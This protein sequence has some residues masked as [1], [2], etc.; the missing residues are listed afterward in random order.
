MKTDGMIQKDVIDELKWA[1]PLSGVSSQIGVSVKDGVV[2]LSGIVDSYSKKIAA[3]K[4]AQKIQGVKV[5]ASDIV[6]KIGPYGVKTDSEIAEAIMNA[7]KWHSLVEEDKVRIK[8]DNGWV[9]LEGEADWEYQRAAVKSSIEDLVG[10]VGISNNITLKSRAIDV[11][12]IKDKIS[13]AFHRSATI[14]SSNIRIATAGSKLTMSGTVRSWS[15]KEAAE[16]IAW[17]SPGVLTVE[18]NIDIDNEVLA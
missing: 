17:S 6:V 13:E 7:L 9:T 1:P 4:A 12:E 10:V 14:D 16:A 2:T 3:E 5:V 15:D 11:K 18:N 8:V